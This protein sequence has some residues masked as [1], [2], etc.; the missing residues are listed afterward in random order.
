[1]P[2]KV[3]DAEREVQLVLGLEPLL[4]VL[5]EDR[6]GQVERVLGRQHRVRHGVDDLTVHAQLGPLARSDVQ[7]AGAHADHLFQQ[8][9]Q[10]DG[11]RLPVT[12]GTRGRTIF[13]HQ[14]LDHVAAVSLMTSS[15]VVMPRET[16]SR[17]SM[18]S[19][20]MPS[21]SACSRSSSALAPFMIMRR[22]AGLM[23]MTS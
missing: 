1:E 5:R 13:C 15:S 20:S 6:V 21:L 9:T 22:S 16:L 7:V 3:L 11:Q 8:R 17:P 14:V 10:V 12:A 18:R 2:C 4:L 23:A 19:V